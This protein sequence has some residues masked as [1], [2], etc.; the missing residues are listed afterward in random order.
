MSGLLARC[1]HGLTVCLLL[2]FA[3]HAGGAFPHTMA[4][5]VAEA[6]RQGYEIFADVMLMFAVGR[7]L[8]FPFEHPRDAYEPLAVSDL[9]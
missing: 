9:D 3:L 1:R 5:R 2:A 8:R 7:A 6:A 4:N